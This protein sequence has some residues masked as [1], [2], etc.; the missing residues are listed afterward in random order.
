MSH[1]WL[2]IP[3]T[4]YE[5]HMALPEVAQAQLLGRLL[6]RSVTDFQ[7]RSLA[8]LGVAGGNGLE[9][10]DPAIV[11][12]IV[13]VDFNADYLAICSQ[14]HA[15][16]F[17]QFEPVLHNLSQGPPAVKPVDLVY[18]GLLLEYLEP[19]S[20]YT[21]LPALLTPGGVFVAVLQLPSATLP[22]V[23]P[24]PY[25]SLARLKPD[26]RF[27]EPA[28]LH[29]SLRGLGFA[30]CNEEQID[31]PGGKSFHYGTFRC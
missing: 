16:R 29:T 1:P 27:V 20:F 18:A 5:G 2:Q 4:D 31:L 6:H 8:I 3:I 14:R 17:A 28:I 23:T 30:V 26:F 19:E 15:A 9:L 21:Q 11:R 13:A 10:I 25:S 12:R 22:E 7:P 24:S